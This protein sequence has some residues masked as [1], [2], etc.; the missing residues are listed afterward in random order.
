MRPSP[1]SAL[2]ATA[3]L[4]SAA[5]RQTGLVPG[6]APHTLNTVQGSQTGL[7]ARILN[8]RYNVLERQRLA[9]AEFNAGVPVYLIGNGKYYFRE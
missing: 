8:G 1:V 6:F 4:R 2:R 7:Y 3:L 5:Q 9:Q